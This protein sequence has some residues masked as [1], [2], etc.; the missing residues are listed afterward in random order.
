V[1]TP[2]DLTEKRKIEHIQISLNEDVEG[3][4]ISTGLENYRFIPNALPEI[5]FQDVSLSASFLGKKINT[6]F[7]IS[8][9]TGGTDTAYSINQHLAEA[10]QERGWAI[11]L[12]SMRAAVEKEELAYTF[13]IRKHAPDIPIIAN[14]G[15]VQLNYGVGLSDCR[16]AV[17]IAEADALVLHL[18]TLQEVFQPEGDTDFS[19]LLSKIEKLAKELQIPVGVKEVGMGIDKNTA[20]QLIRAGV[21]FIDVAG[22]GG[23]SWIQ[24]ESYRSHDPAKKK[25]AEAFLDW[26]LPTAESL[27]SV[28]KLTNDLPLIASGGLKHGV[29]AAKAIALGADL[30]GFGRALLQ[31]AVDGGTEALLTQME[32]IEFECRAAMFGIGVPSIDQLKHTDRLM[33][34]T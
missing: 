13:Q 5:A 11:G 26:G 23:T 6:P 10:A 4:N 14:I 25:A 34:K 19:H 24:V 27:L 33:K 1:D 12:G 3:K 15:A 31:S 22:A 17:E 29:D 32:R 16:R 20:E 2:K 8:S 7:L 21:S 9:M 18:N 28:R 30:S